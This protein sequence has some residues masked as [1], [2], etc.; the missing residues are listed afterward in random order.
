MQAV[1]SDLSDVLDHDAPVHLP[2][3]FGA[4]AQA[5]S[6]ADQALILVAWRLFDD[7]LID[8]MRSILA[9]KHPIDA[10]FVALPADAE[11]AEIDDLAERLAPVMGS[12]RTRH[13]SVRDPGGDA[14]AG[15]RH[16]R[17]TI[18]QA[19]AQL[20]NPAQL[21]ALDQA[22]QPSPVDTS[23]DGEA[24]PHRHLADP[25]HQHQGQHAHR[26]HS[27][28]AHPDH[29]ARSPGRWFVR[30]HQRHLERGAE[31][32]PCPRHTMPPGPPQ[33]DGARRCGP[34]PRSCRVPRA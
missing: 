33:G 32:R 34:P 21:A 30:P 10:E 9:E 17:T 7:S 5:P 11:Q 15:E 3:G 12:L 18:V 27:Q 28:V 4:V 13:H 20:Y 22:K 1:R 25:P 6:A 14:L 26:S 31:D 23:A 16:A 29:Q 2:P 19:I 24:G 8:G